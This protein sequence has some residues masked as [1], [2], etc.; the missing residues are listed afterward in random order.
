M[1][2]AAEQYAPAFEVE[3]ALLFTEQFAFAFGHEWFIEAGSSAP[4]REGWLFE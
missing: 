1:L 2:Y 3:P 4:L